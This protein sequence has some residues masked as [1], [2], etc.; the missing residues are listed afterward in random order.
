MLSIKPKQCSSSV[1]YKSSLIINISHSA[2]ISQKLKY[3]SQHRN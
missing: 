2:I 1:L 3:Q